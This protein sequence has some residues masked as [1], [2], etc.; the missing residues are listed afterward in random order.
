MAQ[1]QVKLMGKATALIWDCC[2]EYLSESSQDVNEVVV[3]LG[4]DSAGEAKV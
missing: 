3:A 1:I 4:S 2:Q